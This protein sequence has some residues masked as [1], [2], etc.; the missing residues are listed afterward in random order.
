MITNKKIPIFEK[1]K[2]C[3]SPHLKVHS[4]LTSSETNFATKIKLAL[5][6]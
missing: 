2:V 6:Y 5:I 3:I 1:G 4:V